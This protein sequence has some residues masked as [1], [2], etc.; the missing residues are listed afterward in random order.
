MN[1]YKQIVIFVTRE[2][3]RI[4]EITTFMSLIHFRCLG[5]TV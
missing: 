2:W 5:L 4:D 3:Q 1:V